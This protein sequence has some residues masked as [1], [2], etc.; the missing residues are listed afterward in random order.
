MSELAVVRAEIKAWERE[1]RS[2]NGKDPS[3][4]DIKD[5][6]HIGTTFDLHIA[7]APSPSSTTAKK[8]KLY[9]KLTKA[10]VASVSKDP[11][12]SSSQHPSTPV[13]P[14]RSRSSSHASLIPNSRTVESTN[15]LPGFNPFSPN[16]NKGK[17]R[18]P[19]VS[20]A[21][22]VTRKPP[23]VNPFATPTKSKPSR[24]RHRTSSPHSFPSI[25]RAT[26]KISPGFPEKPD[27]AVSRARKRLRGEPV[28]PS[29][30]KHKRQRLDLQ[31]V[32]PVSKPGL[33]SDSDDDGVVTADLHP[34]FVDDSPV[35]APPG[36]KSFKFLFEDV[37]PAP[38]FAKKIN[39][40]ALPLHNKST[41]VDTFLPR[42]PR[43]PFVRTSSSKGNLS[44]M[45]S[46]AP[47][48]VAESGLSVK[49]GLDEGRST[50]SD[51]LPGG[52]TYT[53]SLV[54]PSPPDDPDSSNPR[55]GNPKAWQARKRLKAGADTVKD[56]PDED[57][58]LSPDD[59]VIKVITHNHYKTSRPDA[60]GLGWDPSLI[61]HSRRHDL[62][63]ANHQEPGTF[64]VDLPDQ[65]RSVL[66]IS[67]SRS[68]NSNEERVVRS[69]LYG[70]RA[71]H[72][73]PSTGGEIWDVGEG[74]DGLHGDTEAEEDW[75]SEPAPWEAGEL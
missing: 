7:F 21:F 64:S 35:K 40:P 74:D 6:A 38:S 8:Y 50:S 62:I 3:V 60:D 5:H 12:P 59:V 31:P 58:D 51:T 18:D 29:P 2:A 4:A 54:P 68:Q 39:E 66:A 16:K 28:S 46:G 44:D 24:D 43:G 63:D 22:Q 52:T 20:G 13:R 27:K 41:V 23:S 32:L 56:K 70:R 61:P 57:E 30:S 26:P 14:S 34:S 55:P 48:K 47:P 72:Y 45:K 65:L 19:L 17:A 36:G 73:D 49:R 1:F 33:S 37:L 75:E 53:S 25:K 11:Q 9:K 67:P 15:P 69:L 42:G 71:V 10:G